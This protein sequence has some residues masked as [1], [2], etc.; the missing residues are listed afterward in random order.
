[1]RHFYLF[2][3]WDVF[4]IILDGTST[5]SMSSTS[6]L[7]TRLCL[8]MKWFGENPP[9]FVKT[10]IGYSR[11]TIL[12]KRQPNNQIIKIKG[13]PSSWREAKKSNREEKEKFENYFSNFERRNG[14]LN[15]LSPVSRRKRDIKQNVLNFWEEKEKSDKMFSTFEKRKRKVCF[16]LKLRE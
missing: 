10:C 7:P 4:Q 5:F 1:M 9:H 15:F 2:A 8:P 14:N 11:A 13:P 16:L 12:R 3:W 6:V